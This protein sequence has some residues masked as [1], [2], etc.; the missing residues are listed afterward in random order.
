MLMNYMTE[1]NEARQSECVFE[2]QA[3]SEDEGLLRDVPLG[4]GEKKREKR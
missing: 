2:C 4:G 3:I 1:I